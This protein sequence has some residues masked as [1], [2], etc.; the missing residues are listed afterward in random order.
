MKKVYIIIFY[1][2]FSLLQAPLQSEE[3]MYEEAEPV[4]IHP[5]TDGLIIARPVT[6]IPYS[7]NTDLTLEPCNIRYYQTTTQELTKLFNILGR[8]KAVELSNNN[9][10]FLYAPTIHKLL[11][12]KVTT[13]ATRMGL[14]PATITICI[15]PIP[16]D[17]KGL[18]NAHAQQ[19]RSISVNIEII[20]DQNGSIL[21]KKIIG[22]NVLSSSRL[23][24]NEETLR[25]LLWLEGNNQYEHS[26]GLLDGVLAHELGHI[27]HQ[28]TDCN[29][30]NEFQAD[31]TGGRNLS[32][33]QN[34]IN[35]VDM[36]YFAGNLFAS[37]VSCKQ[38]LPIV[39]DGLLEVLQIIIKTL[40]KNVGG[41]GSLSMSS[42]HNQFSNE[43]HRAVCHAVE[44]VVN[45]K[46]RDQLTIVSLLY[47]ELKGCCQHELV[48][49]NTEE[50]H[51]YQA[52][53]R[54]LALFSPQTHPDPKTRREHFNAALNIAA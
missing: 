27:Y 45:R 54:T 42:S 14:D 4:V 39:N 7:I 47:D 26:E 6:E 21:S 24:V 52:L 18:F 51:F 2:I 22:H 3:P 53:D 29:V 28:H 19:M 15:Q 48:S 1:S 11:H 23:T 43:I 44:R 30:T 32:I 9:D 38:H 16:N 10:A 8:Q 31:A 37:L 36:L 20:K 12:A 46:V 34:V 35:S 25:L 40:F 13:I 5:N 33:P 50:E 49:T 17:Q 41:I